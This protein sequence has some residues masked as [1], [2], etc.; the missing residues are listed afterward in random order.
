MP[1]AITSDDT[2]PVERNVSRGELVRGIYFGH[3]GV[4]AHVAALRR[5]QHATRLERAL[6]CGEVLRVVRH[7]CHVSIAV[8]IHGNS[9]GFCSSFREIARCIRYRTLQASGI[10]QNAAGRIELGN[11]D[12]RLHIRRY[13]AGRLKG[14]GGGWEVQLSFLLAK[15]VCAARW[16][17]GNAPCT[18]RST[19]PV[20]EGCI[21]QRATVRT[22]LGDTGSRFRRS[23][24]LI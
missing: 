9:A 22:E 24:H 11:K 12:L 21:E 18:V 16:I 5:I 10:I 1:V 19:M 14:S 3:K 6:C 8:T 7:A 17:N 13:I 15:D 23:G 2:F 20:E 4:C